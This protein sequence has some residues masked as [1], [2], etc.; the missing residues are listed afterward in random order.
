MEI[1]TSIIKEED[2]KILEASIGIEQKQYKFQNKSTITSLPIAAQH[3][4]AFCSAV[5][6]GFRIKK[7]AEYKKDVK[8]IDAKLKD[9]RKA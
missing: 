1:N 7:T 5:L 2:Y 9:I 8:E 6:K 3:L 4:L